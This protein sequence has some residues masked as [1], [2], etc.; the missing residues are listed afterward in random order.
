MIRFDKA[1]MPEV[2]KLTQQEARAGCMWLMMV[3]YFC[4]ALIHQIADKHNLDLGELQMAFLSSVEGM[5]E[6]I[7]FENFNPGGTD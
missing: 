4:G 5:A 1:L 2:E 3:K 7:D 6:E